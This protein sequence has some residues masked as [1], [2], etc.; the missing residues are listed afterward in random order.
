M[1]D[2]PPPFDIRAHLQPLF[3][4]PLLHYQWPD[5]EALNRDL[6]A[7]VLQAERQGRG[8]RRPQV[9]GW[10]S[11]HSLFDWPEAPAQQ[12]RH[13][14]ARVAEALTEFSASD[15]PG[16]RFAYRYESWANIL[17]SGEYHHLHNHPNAVWSGVYYVSAGLEPATAYASG[18]LE[19]VDPRVGTHDL[20]V[21]LGLAVRRQIEFL[22]VA[23]FGIVGDDSIARDARPLLV[24]KRAG[25][26]DLADDAVRRS[27]ADQRRRHLTRAAEQGLAE[28]QQT[29]RVGRAT[30]SDMQS[31]CDYPS[32]PAFAG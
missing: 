16:T 2:S 11:E 24:P 19:L 27:G 22:G 7:L 5:S 29:T 31:W 10:H 28:A 20:Q 15:L 8:Q 12:L 1:P 23:V 13:R 21:K 18:E 14:L 26:G 17:R 6:R 30:V 3:Y 9:G 25:I 4:T 32:L